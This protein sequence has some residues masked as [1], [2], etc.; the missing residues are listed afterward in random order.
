MLSINAAHCSCASVIHDSKDSSPLLPG[1]RFNRST[2]QRGEAVHSCLRWTPSF[3]EKYRTRHIPAEWNRRHE[4]D[5][6]GC[7]RLG[8]RNRKTD[9]AGK[10]FLVGR[11]RARATS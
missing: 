11:L 1:R 8:T 5:E 10:H 9:K 4:A 6:P 2:I 7:T 3:H